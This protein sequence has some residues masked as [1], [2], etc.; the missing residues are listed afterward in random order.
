[1][2]ISVLVSVLSVMVPGAQA[3]A[4]P[5]GREI[6]LKAEEITRVPQ[7]TSKVLLRTTRKDSTSKEKTFTIWRKLKEDGIRYKSLT[8]FHT[9]SE[10]K[11]EAILFIENEQGG[12]DIL[13]Y[14]PAYQKTR[15]LERTQQTSSFMGSD[16]SY[17]DITTAHVDDYRHSLQKEEPC[18]SEPKSTCYVIEGEPVSDKVKQQVGYSKTLSWVRKD[19]S[20]LVQSQNYDLSG[21][22]VKSIQFS[23]HEKLPSGKWFHKKLVVRGQKDGGETLMQFSELKTE[24]NLA[25]SLFTQQSLAKGVK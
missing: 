5:T 2:F 3:E 9:P 10:V 18:P 17:S 14:L 12:N 15:R 19:H 20:L 13:L 6:M 21:V 22:Y 7:F 8:R 16:L 23:D 24:V 1:M 11:N 25:D 4:K